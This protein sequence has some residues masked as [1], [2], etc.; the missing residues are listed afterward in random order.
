VDVFDVGEHEGIPYLVMELLRGV[1][2]ATLLARRGKLPLRELAEIMLPIASAVHAAHA[3]GV[4]HRDLKP[5]NVFLAEREGVTW[6]TVLDFGIS[7]VSTDVDRDLTGSAVILG[8][9]HYLSP[10]QT[11]SA[12][13]ASPFTDQ[14]ALGVMLYEC[15]T[16][17]R[18][19][20]GSTA[21]S[22]MHA[23]VSAKVAPPSAL[24][25]SLPAAFDDVVLQA[26]H[27]DAAKRFA[28]VRELG[29]SLLVWA[30]A[31]AQ[32]KWA[33][34]F[35]A[36]P[37]TRA[38]EP[39]R[40]R[41][42]IAATAIAAGLVLAAM[43]LGAASREARPAA[44]AAP[45][46][47]AVGAPPLSKEQPREQPPDQVP[48]EAAALEVPPAGLQRIEPP[49]A[50]HTGA[51]PVPTDKGPSASHAHRPAVA[52]AVTAPSRVSSER[53]TNGALILE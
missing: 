37:P 6:P 25:P 7:K 43:S 14:Y 53:G 51:S 10:E 35:G 47:V 42:R 5:S 3:S 1:D 49:R 24:D 18:P 4:V 40:P 15:A 29:A 33:P 2:L 13:N 9:V 21:Y 50:A 38:S 32:K 26:M 36:P 16:G 23:I 46:A 28:S 17:R 41:R 39:R 52:P 31:D 19:F 22:V 45:A 12:R 48:P 11:R 34:I 44:P 27:R 30:G 8:T 20:I